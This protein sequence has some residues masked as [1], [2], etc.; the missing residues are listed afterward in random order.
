MVWITNTKNNFQIRMVIWRP[1]WSQ[2]EILAHTYCLVSAL[3]PKSLDI[4]AEPLLLAY[5]TTGNG[6]RLRQKNRSLSRLDM[7][8]W[9]LNDRGFY[10]KVINTKISCAVPYRH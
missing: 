4:F 6:A 10:V 8:A 7:S 5:K 3:A 1:S 9:V 2:H